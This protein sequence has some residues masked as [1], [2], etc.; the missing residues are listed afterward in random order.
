MNKA[1]ICTVVEQ[2]KSSFAPISSGGPQGSV[3]GPRAL[4]FIY[5]RSLPSV[6][7]SNCAMFADDTL[8]YDH[9]SGIKDES[10]C[11]RLGNDVP[12]LDTWASEWCTTA[13]KSTHILIT[14]NLRLRNFSQPVSSLS[15]SGDVIPLVRS[16][17]RIHLGICLLTVLSWSEHITRLLHRVHCVHAET[18]CPSPWFRKP[19]HTPLSK[20]RSR[21]PFS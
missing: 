12:R 8:M 15:I 5:Y 2:L 18:S 1:S 13:S 14:G 19:C 7:S 21:S 6:V 11:S 20:S 17:V 9:C 4:L 10:P 16:A 3:L